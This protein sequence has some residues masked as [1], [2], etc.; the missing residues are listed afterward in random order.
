MSRLRPES[1]ARTDRMYVPSI[2]SCCT[3]A[4]SPQTFQAQA[5]IGKNSTTNGERP[6]LH[7]KPGPE[8]R[9][10]RRGLNGRLHADGVASGLMEVHDCSCNCFLRGSFLLEGAMGAYEAWGLH[11][12]RH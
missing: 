5:K 9:Q 12:V 8:V 4:H 1:H 6:K 11:G 2:V 3:V 10:R 7:K